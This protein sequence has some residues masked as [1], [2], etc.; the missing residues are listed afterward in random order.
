MVIE[1]K[2]LGLL[3]I[4]SGMVWK[5]EVVARSSASADKEDCW[6]RQPGDS[7]PGGQKGRQASCEL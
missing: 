5:Q 6:S 1:A 2:A 7:E 4:G 3:G